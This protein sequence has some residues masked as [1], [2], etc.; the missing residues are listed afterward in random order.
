MKKIGI[1]FGTCNIKASERKK[2]GD[3]VSIKLTRG[4][5]NSMLPNIIAY[6]KKEDNDYYTVMGGPAIIKN[7]NEQNKIR[8]IKS[9]LLEYDWSRKLSFGK[10][11]NAFEVTT[12][13]MKEVYKQIYNMNKKEELSATITVPV[14]FSKRQI[15]FVKKSA[16]KAGFNVNSIITEPFASFFSL[17]NDYMEEEHNVL[18]FDIGGGTLDLCL[19][20]L[21]N[22]DGEIL[23][24]TQSTVGISFGG[25]NINELIIEKILYK[26]NPE[27]TKMALELKN[28]NLL[29][30]VNRYN[31]MEAIDDLKRELFE[32]DN[33]EEDK[34][35]ELIVEYNKVSQDYG[36]ISIKDINSV[37]DESKIASTIK[38]L[39]DDLF[40]DS[41]DMTIDE[42][43]DVFMVGGS[44]N[45]S[46]FRKVIE[47]YLKDNGRNDLDELF[48]INDD[49]D[50][51]ERL[52]A[53]VSKGAT[54]Y[55]FINDK[56]D[57]IKIK[58]RIPFCVF[59]K[60]SEDKKLTPISK[61][62]SFKNY[63][64][65]I[66]VLTD[67]MLKG[68]YIKLF[69]TILGEEGKDVYLGNIKL[70]SKMDEDINLYRLKVNKDGDIIVELGYLAGEH[71]G[72]SRFIVVDE[73]LFELNEENL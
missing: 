7:V 28:N 47:K 37:L 18:I 54:I 57:D 34:K 33:N 55:N 67:E 36:E 24:E 44:S 50:T 45:I 17:M 60:G 25:N 16:Q 43:T 2:N 23:V 29:N 68:K 13:I 27:E 70:P 10:T 72:N 9:H 73:L 41:E 71:S 46:Y 48:E 64:S 1:D 52:Y 12:D 6:D 66:D 61:N 21:K 40:M 31:L 58:D 4:I 30:I 51:E 56:D 20:E 26:R 53:S 11:V 69:Q 8:S 19:I 62:D 42:L 3:I 32:E 65:R 38:K 39:L 49:T 59:T 5:E 15:E 14:N 63:F 35:R 22:E